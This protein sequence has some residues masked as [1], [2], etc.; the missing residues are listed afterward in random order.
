MSLRSLVRS[1]IAGTATV[2]LATGAAG[3]QPV[4]YTT[5]GQFSGAPGFCADPVALAVVNCSGGP[6]GFNLQFTGTA[7]INLG[8]PT[9]G[10]L[11]TFLLTG[12]ATGSVTAPAG[13]VFTLFI[14][15]TTPTGGT[16]SFVGAISG[17]VS[18]S[19][20][21]GNTSQLVWRPQQFVNI[22]PVNYEFIFD[23]T[24]PA[25]GTGRNISIN[26]TTT[27][28][29]R[30]TNTAVPEP[31]TVVLMGSGLAALGFFGARRKKN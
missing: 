17:T 21:N 24:L 23:N 11:G 16:G 26:A 10:Q 1:A 18:T 5:T 13:I 30:I 8:S 12:P 20:V 19:T 14:N 29:A 4:N 15:Q 28:E 7:G 27:L 25:A 3:A 2:A 6:T 22:G 31:A 9:T